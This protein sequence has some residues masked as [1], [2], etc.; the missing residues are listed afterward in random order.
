MNASAKDIFCGTPPLAFTFALGGLLLFPMR[1]G[2]SAVLLE[3]GTPQ[4]LLEAIETYR[5]T[6]CFTSPTGYRAM[7]GILG[8]FDISSLKQCI[9]AGE[10]LP[11]S[12]FQ[13]WERMTG[14][15]IIDGIGSTELL[16][17][18][19]SAR[20]EEVRPGSLGKAVSGYNVCVLDENGVPVLPGIVGRLA[21]RGPTGCRYLADVERQRQYVQQQWNITG[22]ACRMDEDGYV[23]YVAR[24]DDMIV[25]SGYKIAAPEIEGVLLEHPKVGE[26]AVIGVPDIARGQIVKAFVVVKNNVMASDDLA[27]ELQ[28]FVKSRIAPF[29]YPRAIE[30][31]DRLPR[32]AT[33]KL[34]RHILRGNG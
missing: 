18:F 16:H 24:T 23:W 13:T 4:H 32:T 25:S 22:D 14:L 2:A 5:A 34:Q 28:S 19:V 12:T 20:A 30:F 3:Q 15:R 11:L 26:C 21:V 7:L 27:K 8:Q 10:P 17:I 33:G 6:I 9:S 29:K 31:I 1:I